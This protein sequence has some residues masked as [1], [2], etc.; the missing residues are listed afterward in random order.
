[1]WSQKGLK[2]AVE[3]VSLGTFL[4]F[5]YFPNFLLFFFFC[6]LAS[7]TDRRFYASTYRRG[8]V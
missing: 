5:F 1:M 6:F 3:G 7:S 4:I 2:M 8:G